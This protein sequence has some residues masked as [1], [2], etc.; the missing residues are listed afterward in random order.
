MSCCRSLFR[1]CPA[2][3]VLLI[4]DCNGY[5]ASDKLSNDAC[6]LTPCLCFDDPLPPNWAKPLPDTAP[7][8]YRLNSSD[9]N[10][11][12]DPSCGNVGKYA[13]LFET[14]LLGSPCICTSQGTCAKFNETQHPHHKCHP[15]IRKLYRPTAQASG[16]LRASTRCTSTSSVCGSSTTAARQV[17]GQ[18]AANDAS[19]SEA[20][21]SQVRKS[22][23][24]PALRA[25]FAL[26]CGPAL[27]EK[28]ARTSTAA[29]A[30]RL[31]RVFGG[32]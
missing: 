25:A 4:I 6:V 30:S 23:R 24:L 22:G 19:P 14:V 26:W 11:S 21:R 17:Q 18:A 3:A 7:C 15:A 27:V 32:P 10:A 5:S 12:R 1:S 16:D 20:V 8:C 29:R 28:P 9:S 2:H 31:L 13:A